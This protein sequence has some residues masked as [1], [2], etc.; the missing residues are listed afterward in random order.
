MSTCPSGQRA[1]VVF[2]VDEVA[3]LEHARLAH[4]APVGHDAVD[5]PVGKAFADGRGVVAGVDTHRGK[6]RR[7]WAEMAGIAM[8]NPPYAE[9]EGSA[10]G[11]VHGEA[12]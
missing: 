12:R 1:V 2:V 6:R 9:G 10:G 3:L 8:L 7:H 5:I 11:L 4:E